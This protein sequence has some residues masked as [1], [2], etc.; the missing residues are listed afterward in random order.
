MLETIIYSGLVCRI[1]QMRRP[2]PEL[3]SP[4]VI[5]ATASVPD[6]TR[7][8]RL[9]RHAIMSFGKGRCLFCGGRCV[10]HCKRY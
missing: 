8:D 7:I 5:V 6:E 9:D 1:G 10:G 4:A 2:V 3:R